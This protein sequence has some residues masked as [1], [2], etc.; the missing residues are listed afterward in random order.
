MTMSKGYT[1]A[2]AAS[3]LNILS[4]HTETWVLSASVHKLSPVIKTSSQLKKTGQ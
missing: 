2:R 1:P 4:T 3:E